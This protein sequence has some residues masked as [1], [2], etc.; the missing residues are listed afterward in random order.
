MIFNVPN[1]EADFT[2]VG[3][4]FL[5]SV[6]DLEFLFT[7]WHFLLLPAS[8]SLRED[9]HLWNC[10][11]PDF[12]LQNPSW[13]AQHI[14]TPN[15]LMYWS[16]EQIQC[17]NR[18]RLFARTKYG[19]WVAHTQKTRAHQWFG[20]KRFIGKIWGTVCKVCDLPLFGWWWGNRVVQESNF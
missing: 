8:S 1:I 5:L 7:S 11:F 13:C 16:L 4:F 14:V 19:E 18:E 10:H 6:S 2:L 12:N 9:L 17:L 20:G 15:K 3:S